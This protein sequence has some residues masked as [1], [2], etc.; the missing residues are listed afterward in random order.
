M[1]SE[2]LCCTMYIDYFT[3][4]IQNLPQMVNSSVTNKTGSIE[5]VWATLIMHFRIIF[6]LIFK[7]RNAETMHV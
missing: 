2:K 3:T 5:W 4:V 6:L 7:L 1:A